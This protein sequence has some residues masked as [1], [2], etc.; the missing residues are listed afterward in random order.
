MVLLSTTMA[1]TLP[2][3]WERDSDKL[4]VHKSGVRIQLMTYTQKEGWFLVPAELDRP[5]VAFDPNPA[6]RD[7]AFA[8]FEKLKKTAPAGSRKA[9]AA[10]EEPPE[11]PEEEDDDKDDEG[12]EKEEKDD[13]KNADA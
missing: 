11:T 7:S 3:G 5:V 10:A 2:V 4:Y 9:K 12:D 1:F 8:A 6:G 13:D